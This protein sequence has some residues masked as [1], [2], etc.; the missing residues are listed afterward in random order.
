MV[1]VLDP[2]ERLESVNMDGT[3]F[4]GPLQGQGF[5]LIADFRYQHD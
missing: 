1:P 3:L 2:S 5:S 4:V